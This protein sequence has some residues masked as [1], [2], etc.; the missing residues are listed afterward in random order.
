M[1]GTATAQVSSNDSED[2][3]VTVSVS[4]TIAVDVQPAN[5]DYSNAVV[6]N[7]NT[8]SDRGF[9]AIE[10]ENVGSTYIDKVWL[11][12]STPSEQPFGNGSADLYDAGN[13]IEVK[14][15]GFP[16][17]DD[18]DWNYV[19]RKEYMVSSDS[20]SNGVTDVPS[21]IQT[22]FGS[23]YEVGEIR[24]GN[25]SIYFAIDAESGDDSCNNNGDTLRVGNVSALDNRLGTVDF[26][27]STEFGWTE[28]SINS[29]TNSDY[30]QAGVEL[31]WTYT[32]SGTDSTYDLL[33]R[34]SATDEQPHAFV[35]KYSVTQ[36]SADDLAADGEYTTYLLD[37]SN[38][39]NMLAPGEYRTIE[40]AVN[41]P[42]GVAAGS[43]GAGTVSV[44]ITADESADTS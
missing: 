1:A 14:P 35:N 38:A 33:T 5:L 24:R 16:N 19:N 3:D 29:L 9:G 28:Y 25:E 32:E 44:L 31:N 11:E 4:E 30:G 37:A 36:G 42:Q 18:T 40:T 43:V 6:G 39:D 20:G 12:Q 17:G 10:V 41:I 8:T 2:S 21:F 15:V 13:F 27:D 22:D 7:R 34:C 23:P 26:T